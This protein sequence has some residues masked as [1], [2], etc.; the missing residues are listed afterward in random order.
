MGDGSRTASPRLEHGT[1]EQSPTLEETLLSKRSLSPGLSL[2]HLSNKR[3]RSEGAGPSDPVD[4]QHVQSKGAEESHSHFRWDTQFGTDNEQCTQTQ[5]LLSAHCHDT[6][7]SARP[8]PHREFVGSELSSSKL[9]RAV[10]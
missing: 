8:C 4:Q 10:H 2:Q 9:K 3:N 7:Y 5:T 6:W 1:A